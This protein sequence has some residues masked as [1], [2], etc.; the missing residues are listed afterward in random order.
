MVNRLTHQW[1]RLRR[2]SDQATQHTHTTGCSHVSSTTFPV[3]RYLLPNGLRFWCHAR[4]D[5]QSVM[6]LLL[7]R[8]GSRFETAANNGVS[9]FLEH[10]LFTG[11]E[12][13]SEEEVEAIITRR[14]GYHN[15][16]TGPERTVFY[17]HMA[18]QDLD[19]ALDWLSQVAFHP[20]MSPEKIEKE[21]AVIFQER[22]GRYGWLIN[23]LHRVG[24]GYDL[25]QGIRRAIFP[26]SSL[27]LRTKGE[28]AS[29]ERLD[30][31]ALLAHYQRYYAPDNACLIVV[32]GVRPEKV[33]EAAHKYFGVLSTR[34]GYESPAAPALPAHGPHRI[35]VRGPMMTDRVSVVT[36]ARTVGRIHPD[37]WPLEV[38]AEFMQ[39]ELIEEV[40]FRRGLVY[41]LS[42]GNSFLDDAGYFRIR[43]ASSPDHT[44]PILELINERLS[45]VAHL[46]VEP[47]RVEE[48]RCT[49]QGQW[50]LSMEY[51]E[52]RA[53][54]L[55]EWGFSLSPDQPLPDYVTEIGRVTPEDLARVVATYFTP[56]R[57]YLATHQPIL[58]VRRAAHVAGTAVGLGIA[59]WTGY[60]LWQ[61]LSRVRRLVA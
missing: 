54:W 24:L 42:A 39:Q 22:F 4:P 5:T 6:A 38:L 26:D 53:A 49:L 60:S 45:Q 15:G 48:A 7:L 50:L 8:V 47:A 16:Y 1:Q 2:A 41:G 40:R 36:G 33:L 25:E 14:G 34:S 23:F 29:L 20:T 32:G 13:W 17:V 12:R 46:K 51:N 31:A 44:E 55:A 3:H 18:A 27:H 19:L 11:T 10:V 61:R 37:R 52:N 35:T 59:A 56:E 30:R 9:H 43:Y 21:R 28:D 57:R 58:T